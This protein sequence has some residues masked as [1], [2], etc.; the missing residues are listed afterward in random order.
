MSRWRGEKMALEIGSRRITL[1]RAGGPQALTA[2][3]GDW[4]V[5][6]AELAQMLPAQA[7]LSVRVADCWARYW[8]LEPPAGI[9]SLRDCRLLL[10]ARFE[11]LYGQSSADWLIQADWQA[12]KPM[13]AC[14]LPRGLQ[15]AL[16][17]YSLKCLV[18][19]L[20]DDWNQHCRVLAETG[21]W[22][23]ANDGFFNLL[24]WQDGVFRLV[25]QSRDADIDA[26]L[27]LELARLDAEMPAA[28]FWSGEGALAGWQRLEKK[29]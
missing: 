24:Y 8:L 16:A 4:P 11:A 15:Q 23:A 12:G 9:A 18:P 17:A 3:A 7:R 1:I 14:A 20:L 6:A 5:L 27:A 29:A 26:L 19:A 28:R 22:C 10:N 25:R 13:L 2:A 21:V